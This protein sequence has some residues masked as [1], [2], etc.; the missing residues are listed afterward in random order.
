MSERLAPCGLA[1]EPGKKA[2]HRRRRAN[3]VECR[4][5]GNP[6]F[7]A[8]PLHGRDIR[9][10][11]VGVR[12]PQDCEGVA[13]IA[14]SLSNESLGC[15]REILQGAQPA[16][17]AETVGLLTRMNAALVEKW[18]GNRL[19]EWPRMQQDR[20][21]RLIAGSGAPERG[22]VLLSLFDQFDALLQPLA[23]DE[24]GIAG[25][26]TAAARLMRMAAGDLPA[27]TGRWVSRKCRSCAWKPRI[28]NAEKQQAL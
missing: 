18:L 1:V 15:L 22:W 20:A 9:D 25:E 10:H 21:L 13:T 8:D 23:T 17:A 26:T 3:R 11:Q 5:T 4:I 27:G 19:R 16:E 6:H 24:I 14:Q 2:K 28:N 12:W 7:R